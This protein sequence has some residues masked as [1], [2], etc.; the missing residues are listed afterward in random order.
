MARRRT[1]VRR[2][3]LRYFLAAVALAGL[4]GA[5][6]YWWEIQYFAPDEAAFPEQGVA[7]S[8]REGLVGFQSVRA[9]GGSFAYIEASSGA[10]V[11]DARFGRNLAAAR[12]AGLKVGALHRF[13][14]CTGADAQSANFVTMVPRDANL[15]PPAI[16]LEDTAEN[17][18][19]KVS[20]AAV[21]SELLTFVN[22]VELHAGK[23]VILKLS[24]AFE[25]RY[26]VAARMERDLWLVRDRFVP[27][28][29][30]RPWLLWSANTARITEAAEEPLEW[31]VV[32][33]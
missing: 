26:G 24:E 21:E 23:P 17:C 3:F 11:Q 19:E 13:D 2:A 14:P 15:L 33:P 31:V 16:A 32:Q 30:G 29:A 25:E 12:Q 18:P 7:V 5:A 1:P 6:W 22:Q 20:D 9:L 8:D 10:S 27:R 4:L 28:Y